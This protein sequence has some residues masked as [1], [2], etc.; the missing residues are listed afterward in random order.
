MDK[1]VRDCVVTGFESLIAGLSLPDANDRHVLAAAIRC[2]ASVIVTFNE[3]DFPP[4][5]LAPFEIE[6]QHPD[7]FVTHLLDLSPGTVCA[8]VKRQRK[9]LKRQA[10]SVEEF[11]DVLSR[12]KLPETVS[13]LRQFT[14]LI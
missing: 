3:S 7:E 13:Q 10:K 9:N 8:A 4:D 5:I 11:L 14:E 12:Q 2:R 6:A 1:H